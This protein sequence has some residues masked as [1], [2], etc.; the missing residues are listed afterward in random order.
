M[1][2]TGNS[3]LST[4]PVTS[5]DYVQHNVTTTIASNDT[6]YV[7]CTACIVI[8]QIIKPI[9]FALITLF[10]ILGNGL[11]MYVILSRQ[12]MRTVTN[13]LLLNLAIA[14]LSFLVICPPFTAY[15][16]A[17][18]E[19]AIPGKIG[20]IIC[21]LMNYLLNV[22]VYVTIYTLVLISVVRYLTIVHNTAT[23]ELRTRQNI[24]IM[25]VT[26]WVIMIASNIPNWIKNEVFTDGVPQCGIKEFKDARIIFLVFFIV[27]YV[28]PLILIAVFSLCILHHIK[29]QRPTM[30]LNSK[31]ESRSS[32]KKKK[33]GR[34]LILVVVLFAILWLPVHIFLVLFYWKLLPDDPILLTTGTLWQCLAYCNSCVN[35]VIYNYASQDF[36]DSFREVMCCCMGDKRNCGVDSK[37]HRQSVCTKAETAAM[38]P[39]GQ[40]KTAVTYLNDDEEES[41]VDAEKHAE[42]V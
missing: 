13:L 40:N 18:G 20:E 7:P 1:A 37:N 34:V 14:D 10:G 16:D 36:R 26:I 41:D 27:G 17:S 5:S 30:V 29:K 22:T 8:T 38:C 25:I 28:L 24:I 42:Q 6:G 4:L 11:V 19:W 32:H 39:N 35:P 23:R 3:F 9:I 33:A 21:K 15:T 12:K 31:R 2:A